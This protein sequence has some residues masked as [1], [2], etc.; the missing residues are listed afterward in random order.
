MVD[1]E[2]RCERCGEQIAGGYQGTEEEKGKKRV[3]MW[4]RANE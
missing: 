3:G 2:S 1:V 4:K